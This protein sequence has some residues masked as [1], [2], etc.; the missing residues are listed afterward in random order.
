MYPG[1]VVIVSYQVL[2]G[3]FEIVLGA[4]MLSAPEAY[5]KTVLPYPA[6]SSPFV[7]VGGMFIFSLGLCGL[8]GAYMELRQDCPQR[9][10]V[11]WLLRAVMHAGPAV[12]IGT[13]VG[14]DA[15]AN[16]WLLIAAFCGI[17]ALV[18]LLL[19]TFVPPR[20]RAMTH[21]RLSRDMMKSA[22]E[23]ERWIH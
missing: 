21:H 12:L 15:M 23:W 17:C 9:L 1:R 11:V 7:S 14:I 10:Q 2:S 8:L 6:A 5:L 16:G 19:A 3:L 22:A 20:H 13:E 18:E 4:L